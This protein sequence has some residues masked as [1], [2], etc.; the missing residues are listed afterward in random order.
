MART[1]ANCARCGIAAACRHDLAQ[2]GWLC[3][4]KCSTR[5]TNNKETP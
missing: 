3:L 1:R 4:R 5:T 2:H